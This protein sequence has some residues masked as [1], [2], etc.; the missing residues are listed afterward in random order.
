[1][2]KILIISYY[3][4]PANYIAAN[5]PKSFVENFKEHGL[6]PIIVTRHWDG[7][8]NGSEDLERINTSPIEI[9]EN[10]LYTSIKLPY[11][12]SRLG[13]FCKSF[14]LIALFTR[15]FHLI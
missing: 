3:F 14:H 13:R 6:F 1:M 2:K 15:L 4:P 11:F 9:T 12:D 7:D 8:E 10:E 5:R